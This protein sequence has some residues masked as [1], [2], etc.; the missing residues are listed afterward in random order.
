M[1]LKKQLPWGYEAGIL[2][3]EMI[4]IDT[5]DIVLLTD[6]AWYEPKTSV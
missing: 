6:I 3:T 5:Q 1:H 2:A 4:S